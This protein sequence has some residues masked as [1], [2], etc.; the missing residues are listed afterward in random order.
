MSNSDYKEVVSSVAARVRTIR[1]AKKITVQELAHRCD[2]ERS[3]M[4]RIE[5][6]R[7]NITLKTLCLISKALGVDISI[8]FGKEEV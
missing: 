8:F 4:S 3:N 2:M 1:K 7:V 5:S 6:G